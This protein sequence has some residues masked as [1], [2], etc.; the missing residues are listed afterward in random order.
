MIRGPWRCSDKPRQSPS[1]SVQRASGEDPA[2]SL[3]R[4]ARG[5]RTGPHTAAEATADAYRAST[6]P[7]FE[8]ER[9]RV[10]ADELAA[11]EKTLSPQLRKAITAAIEHVRQYQE[12]IKPTDPRPVT[13]DGAELGLRFTPVDSVGLTVPGGTA[14]LF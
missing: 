4:R 5:A 13:L 10:S 9:I 8:A 12:H 2:Y 11:A 3:S 6:D 14:V 7:R 1:G